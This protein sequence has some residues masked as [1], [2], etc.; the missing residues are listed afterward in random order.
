MTWWCEM[1]WL[2]GDTATAGVVLEVA[3]GQISSVATGVETPPAGSTRLDGLTLPGLA[4]AHSHAFHRA[5]RG[6]TQAGSGSFWTWRDQM[7]GVAQRLDPD[8]YF[9]LARATY[10]EMALAGITAVGEFHYVH[11]QPDGTPYADANAMGEALLSAAA[12]AGIRITLLDT[13]YL[14]GGLDADGHQPLG[15]HQRRFAD[16]SADAWAARA[17]ARRAGDHAV[18]GA[19]IHSVRAVDPASM[20]VV[21]EWAAGQDAPVHVHL[22]EQPAENEACFAHHGRTPTELLHDAG[23]LGE[24]LTAVHATHLTKA[25]LGLLATTRSGVCLC[26]TTERDLADGIGPAGDLAAAGVPLSLGS[27]SHAVVDPFEEARA[28]EL[29]ER[30]TTMVRGTHPAAALLTAATAAGYAALG[31][32]GGGLLAAGAPADLTTVGLDSVRLAGT[33]SDTALASVVFAAT[34]ADVTHVV[35]AGNVVVS[36]GVHTSVEVAAELDA[37]IRAVTEGATA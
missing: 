19:A 8:A 15:D 33:D 12:E 13:C 35:V 31:R 29:D 36:D 3:D 1:A 21:G 32:N 7:Y 34:A 28:V 18:L 6:R 14:H 5:L 37:S 4:N 10:A 20:A 11:H 30:L 16:G 27:D 2:G 25:D 23:L 22:S 24:R 17:G 9:R 26:P